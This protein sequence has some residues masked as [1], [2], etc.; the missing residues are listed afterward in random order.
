MITNI[1]ITG[2]HFT[3]D[4]AT[5]KYVRRKIGRLDRYLPRHARRSVSADVKLSEV[6]RS[7]GNKYE[8]E[9]V[10]HIPDKNV[11]ARDSTLNVLA[12]TDIVERKLVSQLHRYKEDLIPHL[13]H[14][15]ILGRFKRSYAREQQA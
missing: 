11:T 3:P 9:V 5:K 12:A 1:T 2:V 14:R 10:M 8:V 15:R 4:E 13:S 6:N 7:H